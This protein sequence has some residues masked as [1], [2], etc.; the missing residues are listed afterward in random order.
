LLVLRRADETLAR[1][2]REAR[3]A[4]KALEGEAIHRPPVDPPRH[5]MPSV[6]DA[7]AIYARA[8]GAVAAIPDKGLETLPENRGD[9]DTLRTID[10]AAVH[11]FLE[12]HRGLI[13]DLAPALAADHLTRP[14]D[15]SAGLNRF[16]QDLPAWQSLARFLDGATRNA[17]VRGDHARV[18]DLVPLRLALALDQGMMGTGLDVLVGMAVAR[19]ALRDLRTLLAQE[20]LAPEALA[21]LAG[22]LDALSERH[23]RVDWRLE[24]DIA[25]VDVPVERDPDEATPGWR[26]LWSRRV[27]LADGLDALEPLV[28]D[29]VRVARLPLPRQA[30]ALRELRDREGDEGHPSVGIWLEIARLVHGAVGAFEVELHLARTAVALARYRAE[31][32]ASPS[33]LQDLV[34]AYL[35]RVKDCPLH[36]RPLGCREGRLW[37]LGGDGDDDGGRPTPEEEDWGADGDLVWDLLDRALPD[38]FAWA[39]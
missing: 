16:L 15:L 38:P 3:A 31:R 5:G 30:E 29:L 12:A 35:D 28:A 32:G 9:P 36:G 39:R 17:L 34:P 22:R 11:A 37:C 27:Y 4:L 8:M 14:T 2:A 24:F 13:E 10:E 20:A 26:H 19:G 18:A 33:R 7:R 25:R 23:P 21:R 6:G 1:H